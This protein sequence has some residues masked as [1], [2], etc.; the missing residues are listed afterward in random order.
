MEA[1]AVVLVSAAIAYYTWAA[2][3][4]FRIRLW[5]DILRAC[6]VQG[7]VVL[8]Y[9]LVLGVGTGALTWSG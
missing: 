5:I 4:L 9:L 8:L 7:I 3:D 6:L 2:L 1:Y